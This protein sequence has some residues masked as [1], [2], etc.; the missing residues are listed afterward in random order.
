VSWATDKWGGDN[1]SLYE[2][3]AKH[4]GIEFCPVYSVVGSVIS[5]DIIKVLSGVSEPGINWFLYDSE[6]C[7]GAIYRT[8]AQQANPR[9]EARNE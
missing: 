4:I 1:K 2:K 6:E 8:K 3:A 7:Y 5:Q 9:T